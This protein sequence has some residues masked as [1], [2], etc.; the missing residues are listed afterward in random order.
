M[1]P[2]R[3]R[4]EGLESAAPTVLAVGEGER[5]PIGPPDADSWVDVKASSEA[6][7]GTFYF[8]EVQVA[9]GIPGP[10]PHVHQQTHDM[11]FVLSGRL[12]VRLDDEERVVDRGAFVCVPPGVVHT[13]FNADAAPVRFLHFQTPGGWEGH[14][15]EIQ[16]VSASGKFTEEQHLKILARYDFQPV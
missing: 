15:R 10:P 8:S 6:T 13:Y 12:G 5:F 16:A 14:L 9:P 2:Q 3:N 1:H 11:F 7:A 4:P